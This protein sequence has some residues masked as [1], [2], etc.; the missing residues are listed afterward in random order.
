M[1]HEL[2]NQSG[3][4]FTAA[5]T[6]GEQVKPAAG[7]SMA[8]R[9]LRAFLGYFAFC[10][11]TIPWLKKELRNSDGWINYNIGFTVKSGEFARTLTIKDGKVGTADGVSQGNDINLIFDNIGAAG[12]LLN[13]VPSDIYD[14]MIKNQLIFDGDRSAALFAGMLFCRIINPI[15][16]AKLKLL[17]MKDRREREKTYSFR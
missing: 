17:K 10:Y 6:S 1:I 14:L 16:R 13:G 3:E 12:R 9:V 2:N 7:R 15:V 5:E 8:D 11:N 4:H